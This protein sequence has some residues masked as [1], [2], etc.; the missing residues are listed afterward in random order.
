M[1]AQCATA[2]APHECAFVHLAT[3]IFASPP[4][5]CPQKQEVSA[6]VLTAVQQLA[7]AG[8]LKKWG[9]VETPP[10]RN[11]LQGEHSVAL[12]C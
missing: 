1:S 8:A 3:T 10:R 6:E 5:I 7:E 4:L 9:A 11:V 2:A 12:Y